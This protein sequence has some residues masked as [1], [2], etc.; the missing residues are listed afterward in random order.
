VFAISEKFEKILKSNIRPK[1]EPTIK[2]KG[3]GVSGESVELEWGAGNIQSMTFKRGIDPLGRTLPYMELTWT[4]LYLGKFNAENFPEKYNSIKEHMTVELSVTQNL[5]FFNSWKNVAKGVE[6]E[7]I[8]FPTMYLVGKPVVDGQTIT[9]TA[10]DLMFFLN[11]HNSDGF[12]AGIDYVN[13][14]RRFLLDERANFQSSDDMV[15]AVFL[16]D[17]NLSEQDFGVLEN[18]IILDDETRNILMNFFSVKGFYWDFD[19]KWMELKRATNILVQQ[20]A[21][22]SFE[23]NIMYKFPE[24][25]RNQNVSAYL[26][27]QYRAE[28]TDETP[29][30]VKP[31]SAV[32]VNGE[33][34]NWFVFD[35]FG[36]PEAK[37]SGFVV[38]HIS[39]KTYSTANELSVSP[40]K[41]NSY[42]KLV[43]IQKTGIPYEEDN[44]CNIY[45]SNSTET[46]EKVD[47]L[48][49][50]FNSECYTMAF[51]TLGVLPVETGDIVSVETNLFEG[52]KRLNKKGVVVELEVTYN[53]AFKQK[54]IVHEV[55]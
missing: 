34:V 54:T 7:T 6:A 51:E 28:Q 12:V 33:E 11:T 1:S 17:K 27:K 37:G 21:V 16:T 31:T 41:Y 53:G 50:Y 38:S 10:R 30:T 52:E 18:N 49:R 15:F 4:E 14:A 36:I 2:L 5:G 19:R 13:P 23:G 29:Y 20:N 3:N 46:M 8:E 43:A 44:P 55:K 40:V 45:G 47:F 9:W 25:T 48:S 32:S 24:L 22:F 42:E 39:N 26:Y 35:G